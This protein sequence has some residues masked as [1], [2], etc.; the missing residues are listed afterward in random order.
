[1]TAKKKVAT[2]KVT[3]KVAKKVAKK[4]VAKKATKQEQA[5]KEQVAKMEADQKAAEAAVNK[6]IKLTEAYGKAMDKLC[7]KHNVKVV[8]QAYD[9]ANETPFMQAFEIKNDFEAKA[10]VGYTKESLRL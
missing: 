10:I 1:M 6:H 7:K 2:K 4:K 5:M 8:L 9:V 3:K